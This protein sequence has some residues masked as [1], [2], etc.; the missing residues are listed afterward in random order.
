MLFPKAGH[1]LDKLL[2]ILL[3]HGSGRHVLSL[4]VIILHMLFVVIFV[5]IFSELKT[6]RIRNMQQCE[7]V[8]RFDNLSLY[9][10]FSLRPIISFT[11][12]LSA[13][14]ASVPARLAA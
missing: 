8:K 10:L 11:A 4:N 6:S 7:Q 3:G 13:A 5:K 1:T 9:R 2:K 12:P 14:F